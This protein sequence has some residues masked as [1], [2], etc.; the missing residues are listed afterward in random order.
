[1]EGQ[2]WSDTHSEGKMENQLIY[3]YIYIYIYIKKV[4][5]CKYEIR[6]NL[7]T[8][9]VLFGQNGFGEEHKGLHSKIQKS[10]MTM[11]INSK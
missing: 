7:P 4:V 2:S 3:I 5:G 10:G 8:H 9:E 6:P 1:M 11:I